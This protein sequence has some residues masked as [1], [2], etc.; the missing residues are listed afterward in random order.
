MT[1]PALL[2]S[3]LPESVLAT[4]KIPDP[5][6]RLSILSMAKV[7]EMESDAAKKAAL[8]LE[9]GVGER[10]VTA[11]PATPNSRRTPR[12]SVGKK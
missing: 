10:R 1:A 5:L 12:K 8:D 6:S 11:I 7:S 4:S 3:V 9:M 2:T